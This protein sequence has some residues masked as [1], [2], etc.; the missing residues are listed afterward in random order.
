MSV[1]VIPQSVNV[2]QLRQLLLEYLREASGVIHGN[3]L[4]ERPTALEFTPDLDTT[5]IANLDRIFGVASRGDL[6][7]TEEQVI[8]DEKAALAAYLANSSPTA[9]QTVTALK[10]LIRV[11]RALAK[12]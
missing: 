5:E 3:G 8:R 7:P 4:S 6:S 2:T 11:V 9:A 1:H 10:L 12:E